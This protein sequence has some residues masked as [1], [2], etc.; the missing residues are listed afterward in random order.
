MPR[1]HLRAVTFDVT[2]TLIHSPRLA[3]IYAEVLGRHGV[4][5]TAAGVARL[6]PEVFRELSVSSPVFVD[7]FAEHPGG[8]RGW[9][10]DLIRRLCQ[11][12]DAP[13]P[14]LFAVAELYQRF[15]RADAWRVYADVPESLDTLLASGYR[16]GIVSNWDER[17]PRLLDNLDLASRFEVVVRSSEVGLAK[18]HPAIF[19]RAL[20]ALGLVAEEALHVGDQRLEDLEGARGAGLQ[21]LLLHRRHDDD[22]A[23]R[24]LVAQLC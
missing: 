18:P 19:Q 17:L 1:R 23:L 7:R 24:D 5:V 8:G 6:F 10:G 15:E 3:E 22:G 11:R 20:D 21:A 16:L 2:G 12:L 9:W 4:A 14:S 13:E